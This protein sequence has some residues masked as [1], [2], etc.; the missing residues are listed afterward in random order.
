MHRILRKCLFIYPYGLQNFYGIQD[1]AKIK[2]LQFGRRFQNQ[3]VRYLEYLSKI[4]FSDEYNFRI[5]G[6]VNK[7]NVRIWGT[8]RPTECNQSF[9]HSPSV[10]I[11]CAIGKEKVKAQ[12]FRK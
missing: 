2:R 4:V 10:I 5:N 8:E 12:I 9:M 6:S 7:Q 11:W 3:R 1:S